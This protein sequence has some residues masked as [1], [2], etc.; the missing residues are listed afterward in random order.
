MPDLPTIERTLQTLFTTEADQIAR[1]TSLVQRRSKLTGPLIV[2]VL[3]AGFLQHPTASYNILAQVAADH[4]VSVTR[5]A[6]HA[7]LTAAAVAFFRALFQRS[8]DLLQQS[9]RLP[10]PILTQFRAVYLLDSSQVALPEGLAE[11]YPGTGGDGPQA[12]IKWQVLWEVLAGNLRAVLGQPA[13]QSDQRAAATLPGLEAGSLLLCDLGYVALCLLA[14]LIAHGVYFI[15]RW[16]PRFEAFTPTGQPLDLRDHLARCPTDLVELSLCVGVRAQ[17]PLRVVASRVPPQVR[18]QRR[19]RAHATEKK[20]GFQYSQAYLLLLDWNIYIT[21]VAEEQ[22]SGAQVRLVYGARW[23]IELLFKL[24]KSAGEL[25]NVRGQQTGRVLCE[26]YAK[27]IGLAVFGYLSAP[28]RLTEEAELSPVKAW[29]VWQRQ[30]G[31]VAAALRSGS[32]LAGILAQV[33]RLWQQFALKERRWDRPTTFQELQGQPLQKQPQSY[34]RPRV[35]TSGL[36]EF[37]KSFT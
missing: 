23:Q 28:V 6:V 22:L 11:Q 26:L 24:W 17:L 14:A 9:V 36:T 27:L 2:L 21:N 12:G 35:S 33:Y 5:Q 37:V 19:R 25:A 1:Q 3:G 7:R 31:R 15:C 34:C 30:S 10:I 20:R 8:L 18:E 32:G 29:Q 4:G 16:N 13:K